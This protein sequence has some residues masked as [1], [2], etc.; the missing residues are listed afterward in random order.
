MTDA[1]QW[2]SE[3][4]LWWLLFAIYD[5]RFFVVR[6]TMLS[7]FD[8][9]GAGKTAW[10]MRIFLFIGFLVLSPSIHLFDPSKY[11]AMTRLRHTVADGT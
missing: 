7:L 3:C 8:G 10:T 6:K 9:L 1:R 11:F 4:T 2:V 5:P